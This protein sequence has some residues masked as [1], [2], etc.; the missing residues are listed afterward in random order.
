MKNTRRG[1]GEKNSQFGKY[2]ITDDLANQKI[3][4]DSI[5]P[6]GWHR[7]RTIKKNDVE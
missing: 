6:I 2:W 1:I 4:K 5:I 7:G 3:D